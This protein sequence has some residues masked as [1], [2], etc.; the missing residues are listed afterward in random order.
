[1]KLLDKTNPAQFFALMADRDMYKYSPDLDQYVYDD[2]FRLTSQNLEIYG[3]GDIKHSYINWC[4]DYARRQGITNKQEIEDAVRNTKIQLVY[5]AGGFTDKQ[6]L[7]VYT[8]KSSPESSNTDLLLP[9]ESFEILLYRNEPFDEV[10]YSS[11][12]VQQVEGLSLIHI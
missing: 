8:E 6:Y 3:D 5:R 2:R 12:V 7:K 1:M 9:D 11:V 4:V 10:T